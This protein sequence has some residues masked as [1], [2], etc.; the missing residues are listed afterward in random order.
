MKNIKDHKIIAFDLVCVNLYPFEKFIQEIPQ[1]SWYDEAFIQKAIEMI[2]IG[3]PTMIRA[4]AKNHE[5]VFVL[6][7]PDQYEEFLGEISQKKRKIPLSYR[8]KLAYE[9]FHLTA[10][11]EAVIDHFFYSISETK[12]SV[13]GLNRFNLSLRKDMNLRYGENPHQKAGFY[14]PVYTNT[15]G[16]QQLHGKELSYNNLLDLD[17][18]L[19]M[20]YEFQKPF[21]CIFK[22]T[23]PC[24]AAQD[25]DQL[26]SLEKAIA[27]DPMSCFGGIVLF[28]RKLREET[29]GKLNKI[30]FEIII[31]PDFEDKAIQILKTKKNLRLISY[32]KENSSPNFDITNSLGGF[33]L[34]E[35]NQKIWSLGENSLSCVTENKPNDQDREELRFSWFMVKHVKSNAIVFSKN[36]QNY[37]N[38]SR[39]NESRR[40]YSFCYR[41]SK[42]T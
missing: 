17:S 16:W 35:K 9:A 33:L 36:K 8:R 2:D 28:N 22:H 26:I 3:G 14:M 38:R 29:A 37:W 4:A 1:E 15:K 27:S 40:C 42:R 31:A 20:A 12:K 18:A 41:E 39:A 19:S 25:D 13:S 6:T 7:S 21:C 32:E 30:F 23:N 5:F 34:Q 11:Y 24:G 10:G